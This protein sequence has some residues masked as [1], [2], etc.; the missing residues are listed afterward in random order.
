MDLAKCLPGLKDI[1]SLVFVSGLI[2]TCLFLARV[3]KTDD[4]PF[5]TT[6]SKN[7]SVS[8]SVLN[9]YFSNYTYI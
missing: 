2:E 9:E 8:E 5:G 3:L 1:V 4:N 6:I 7:W